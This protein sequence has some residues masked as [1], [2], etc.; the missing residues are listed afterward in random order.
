MDMLPTSFQFL[1]GLGDALEEKF[2][3]EWFWLPE[4]ITW[5]DF[6]NIPGEGIYIPQPKDILY[7]I[8]VAVVIFC[9]RIFFER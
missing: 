6:E 3:S 8:P 1:S 9:A 5:K 4:N 7:C 2:F